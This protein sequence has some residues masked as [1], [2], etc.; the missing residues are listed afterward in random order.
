MDFTIVLFL[1]E[2]GLSIYAIAEQE[3]S[4]ADVDVLDTAVKL[5]AVLLTEDKDFGA[6]VFRLRLPHRGVVLLRLSGITPENKGRLAGS[7][8]IDH[9]ADLQ[10]SFTVFDGAKIR[11]WKR[12]H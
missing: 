4:I 12:T 3:P 9:L 10:D 6:L 5:H 8:I 7:A 2:Q 1:H 11:I